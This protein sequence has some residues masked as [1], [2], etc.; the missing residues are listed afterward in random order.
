MEA[1]RDKNDIC[2][3]VD[4]IDRFESDE[5]LQILRTL[6][7][8]ITRDNDFKRLSFIIPCDP[9]QIISNSLKDSNKF[10]NPNES[11]RKY[12]NVVVNIPLPIWS[13]LEG[14]ATELLKEIN[15][16][17]T[18]DDI[19]EISSSLEMVYDN[20]PRQIKQFINNFSAQFRLASLLQEER[21]IS[22][23]IT[24]DVPL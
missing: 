18:H 15:I 10:A 9:E 11:L 13:D 8:F 7:T 16:G 4:N 14:Y 1:T 6:K 12:F 17:L 5:A 19:A 24:A 2:I 22:P 23:N 21:N 20:N 3:I